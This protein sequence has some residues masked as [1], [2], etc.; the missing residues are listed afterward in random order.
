MT[1]T[2]GPCSA[3]LFGLRI[4]RCGIVCSRM[5]LILVEA[6]FGGMMDGNEEAKL[7]EG[8]KGG[9]KN[10]QNHAETCS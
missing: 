5:G 7:K 8:R 4:R 2:Q 6:P 9:R 3:P 10:F 1:A